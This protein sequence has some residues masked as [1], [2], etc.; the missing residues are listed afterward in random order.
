MGHAIWLYSYLVTYADRES[1]ELMRRNETIAQEI[2]V[3][4]RTLERW[5]GVLRKKKYI[6]T[7]KLQ[8]GFLI[9]IQN[10][11]SI[12]HKNQITK[13]GGTQRVNPAKSAGRPRQKWRTL[14][15][16]ALI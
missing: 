6:C 2:D 15:K 4:L 14:L 5:F 16:M 11:R 1:G 8:R 13:N 9:K 12:G 3:P 10:W 7:Q